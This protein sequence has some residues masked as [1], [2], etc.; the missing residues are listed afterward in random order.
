MQLLLLLFLLLLSSSWLWG[1][2]MGS[3]FCKKLPPRPGL[4]CA[5][6]EGKTPEFSRGSRSQERAKIAPIRLQN[7]SKTL[8]DISS[9]PTQVMIAA[10]SLRF[11]VSHPILISP[12]R[13]T[14]SKTRWQF[15][16]TA[17]KSQNILGHPW[18]R[19]PWR[20]SRKCKCWD[21]FRGVILWLVWRRF[22][23]EFKPTAAPFQ[24]N[25]CLLLCLYAFQF[26]IQSSMLHQRALIAGREDN[27]SGLGGAA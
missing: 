2:N 4:L 23:P 18:T 27:L 17:R 20:R 26:P 6:Y 13:H 1:A 19:A 12:P 8:Q 11:S 15:E 5:R 3:P 7:A 25:S 10:V 22:G 21:E 14:N 16:V 24:P 9:I